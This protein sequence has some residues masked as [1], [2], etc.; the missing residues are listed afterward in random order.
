MELLVLEIGAVKFGLDAK[1]VREVQRVAALTPLPEAGAAVEGAMNLRGELVPVLDVRRLI[2]NAPKE[3]ALTDHFVVF[4]SVSRAAAV[5]VDRAVELVQVDEQS[6][7][8]DAVAESK[9]VSRV[10]R[11]HD[12]FVHVLDPERLLAAAR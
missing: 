12:E 2:G 11:V 9:F 6:A 4:G 10:V 7:E 5:R 1:H 3:M 8:T